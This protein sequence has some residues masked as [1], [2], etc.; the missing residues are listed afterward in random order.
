MLPTKV[1]RHDP[2]CLAW[3]MIMDPIELRRQAELRAAENA[4][5]RNFLKHYSKLSAEEVDRLVSQISDRV[6]KVVDCTTCGNCC[7]KVSPMFDKKDVERLARHLGTTESEFVAKHLLPAESGEDFPWIMRE[8]PCPFLRENRCS[9]Y[10]QRPDSCRCY[11]YLD[12]PDFVYRTL[13]MMERLY[14]CPA[15]FEVWE[16]LK[17]ATGFR[18]RGRSR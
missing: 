8:R 2:V 4:S 1:G 9:V 17:A 12:K 10:D 6:W 5:F 15:V 3:I 7:R 16:Q 13:S 18:R 11:P 14:D